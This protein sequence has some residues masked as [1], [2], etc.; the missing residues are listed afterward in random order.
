MPVT[1]Y[2]PAFTPEG[3]MVQREVPE[4][5][6]VAFEQSGYTKGKLPSGLSPVP[7]PEIAAADAAEAAEAAE[8]KKEAAEAK[9]GK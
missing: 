9:K 8:R 1:M 5:D 4:A 3:E 6:V 7:R 2:G